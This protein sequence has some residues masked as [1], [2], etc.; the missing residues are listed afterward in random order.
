MSF[1]TGVLVVGDWLVDEHWVVGKHRAFSSSRTGRD[2][3]RA[4]HQHTSSVRSLCGAGQV[5]SILHQATDPTGSHP[6]QIS[7]IGLW[8]RG[9]EAVLAQMLRPEF[10]IGQTPHILLPQ[11]TPERQSDNVRLY[12]LAC[13]DVT[14][15]TTRVIRI[16]TRAEDKPDLKQRVDWELPLTASDHECILSRVNETLKALEPRKRPIGHIVIKDL[17]KGVISKELVDYL[18]AKFPKA[19]WYISSKRWL[20]EWLSEQQLPAEQVRLILIPHLAAR[21]AIRYGAI[22]SASWVTTEGVPT[23]DALDAMDYLAR[24]FRHSR[25]VVL[26]EGMRLLAREP[27]ESTNIVLGHVI[28]SASAADSLPFTPMA[29]VFFPALVAHMITSSQHGRFGAQLEA[30]IHFTGQ[31]QSAENRRLIHEDWHPAPEQVLKLTNEHANRNVPLRN[32]L[33]FNWRRARED[34]A[35]AYTKLGIVSVPAADSKS[36]PEFQIW[37]AT[38]ELDGYVTCIKAKRSQILR[39]VEAGS[40]MA[41]LSREERR[42]K[43]FLIIDSPGSGKSYMVDCL[44]KTLKLQTLKFNITQM[45]TRQDLTSCFEAIAAAQSQNRET[46]LLVFVDEINSILNGQHVFDAFLEPLEDGKFVKDGATFQLDPC[47]WLFA[48][49]E[50]ASERSA[51]DHL[52]DFESRLSAPAMVLNGA[53]DDAG[54]EN[55][56]RVEQVYVAVAAI[57][58]VL[59]DVNKVSDK[60]LQSFRILPPGVGP[61]GIRRLVRSLEYVQYGR[62]MERNLPR[63][64]HERLG[65]DHQLLLDWQQKVEDDSNLVTIKSKPDWST[66]LPPPHDSPKSPTTHA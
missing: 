14:V 12:N 26:P 3:S 49:T 9:D 48:G 1:P 20:P 65:I 43:S 8:H 37:R 45:R 60:V 13:G 15:G 16:Y 59:P 18:R 51:S 42:S 52:P 54:F 6:F 31:W 27:G 5:A 29:S 53:S 66:V 47:L 11:P 36:C 39:L 63:D 22:S 62:I 35:A 17:G 58:R 32:V 50:F 4:L 23:A 33:T 38:T 46:L 19:V 24:I 34:W 10:N 2:H 61:R 55:L 44:A 41:S 25:L 64:W 56:R 28:P 40:T 30:A 21:S 7:G 57:R